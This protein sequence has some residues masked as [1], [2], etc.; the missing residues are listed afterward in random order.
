MT[1]PP[2]HID[3][4]TTGPVTVWQL[5]GGV[6][7]AAC[8]RP[9][10]S[11]ARKHLNTLGA[12]CVERGGK[13]LGESPG[14]SKIQRARLREAIDAARGASSVAV[15][16]EP[17]PQAEA[18]ADEPLVKAPSQSA[19]P[20]RP[21]QDPSLCP[22]CDLA[23]PTHLTVCPYA[24]QEL[25]GM[26]PAAPAAAPVARPEAPPVEPQRELVT[27]PA[28]AAVEPVEAPA[29]ADLEPP[30]VDLPIATES[31]AMPK[32]SKPARKPAAKRKAAP[33]S[34]RGKASA[35]CDAKDCTRPAG[36]V[37]ANTR[38]VARPFCPNH[39]TI[40]RNNGRHTEGG[41]EAIAE[42]LRTGTMPAPMTRVE[43][44]KRSVEARRATKGT[45]KP[46][47]RDPM[48]VL[49]RE[50]RTLLAGKLDEARVRAIVA[51]QLNDNRIRSI[52]T[53][54]LIDVVRCLGVAA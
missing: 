45:A 26:P 8:E 48:D 38:D 13:I 24:P 12:G 3:V 20:R 43:A 37:Y 10:T 46:P 44:G 54:V 9:D 30:T 6:A 47:M 4:P 14:L 2:Q 23:P 41:E 1:A 27:A 19:T 40:L 51:E 11:A 52:V 15:A 17:A 22:G 39:R 33:P 31:P 53:E 5:R 7:R 18:T 34:G 25:P 21:R 35:A 28:P 49:V 16:V 36:A 42:M 32:P 29:A 50:L